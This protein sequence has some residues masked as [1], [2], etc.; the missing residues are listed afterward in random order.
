MKQL[1]LLTCLLG[2]LIISGCADPY[3]PTPRPDY[4]IRVVPSGHG[5]FVA[6]PPTCSSWITD[7]T[8]PFDHQPTPQ[9]GCATQRN[10]AM[11]VENP[12]DLVKGRPLGPANGTTAV[13]SMLRYTN[14]QTRGL[15]WTGRESNTVATTT[16]SKAT[17]SI[18]GEVAG[19]GSSSSAPP[20]IAP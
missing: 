15:L 7:T 8:D 2:L 9:F 10:L 3:P 5:G 6:V 16:S 12:E 4:V 11:M 13:G 17:S 19:A 1:Y 14:D 20:P 18:S